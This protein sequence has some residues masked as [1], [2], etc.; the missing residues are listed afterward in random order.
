MSIVELVSSVE[1]K[2]I[3]KTVG[4]SRVTGPAV[5]SWFSLILVGEKPLPVILLYA[6]SLVSSPAQSHGQLTDALEDLAVQ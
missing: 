4:S 1:S 5:L 3:L 2:S 6:S